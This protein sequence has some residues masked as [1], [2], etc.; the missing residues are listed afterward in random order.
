MKKYTFHLL[1][2]TLITAI[3]GYSG[4]EFLGD[5]FVRFLC[6]LFGIGLLISCLD[7]VIVSRRNRKNLKKQIEKIRAEK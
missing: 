2:L 6:L 1:V 3:L 5:T 7:A 4:F